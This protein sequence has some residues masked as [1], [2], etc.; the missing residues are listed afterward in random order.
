[1]TT[2]IIVNIASV[3]AGLIISHIYHRIQMRRRELFWSMDTTSLVKGYSSFFEKLKIKY[4]GQK[5]ENLTVSEITFWNNGNEIID[6]ADIAISLSIIPRTVANTQILDV[7]VIKT[8]TLG[9]KFAAQ[10]MPDNPNINLHFDYLDTQQGAVIQ[11]IHTGVSELPLWVVGEVKGVKEI[12]YKRRADLVANMARFGMYFYAVMLS[13]LFGAYIYNSILL[14]KPPVVSWINWVGGLLGV[15]LMIV[16]ASIYF[17]FKQMRN[18]AK[19]PKG[20][21]AFEKHDIDIDNATK[22]A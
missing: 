16:L 2:D 11:V 13:G 10:K 14:Q 19:I 18:T 17:D 22:I 7:K 20:L 15:F 3:I 21:S 8:S 9:N 5:I 4:E 1:M 6:R 12:Q